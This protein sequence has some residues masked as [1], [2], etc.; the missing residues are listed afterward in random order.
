MSTHEQDLQPESGGRE[1]KVEEG[2]A[3]RCRT[4]ESVAE[5]FWWPAANVKGEKNFLLCGDSPSPLSRALSSLTRATARTP[6]R[7]EAVGR[8]CTEARVDCAKAILGRR[9][10]RRGRGSE[11]RGKSK[12]VNVARREE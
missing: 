7:R 4:I 10:R 2:R 11:W 1:K 12:E 8:A 5:I 3:A 6:A 9:A